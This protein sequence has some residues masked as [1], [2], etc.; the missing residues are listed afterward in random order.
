MDKPLRALFIEDVEDDAELLCLELKRGG[1]DV[2]YERVDTVDA[3]QAALNG[4]AWDF[5]LCD[6]TMPHLDAAKSLA[7]VKQ[8]G[9]DIPFIIVSGTIVEETAIAV[10]RGVITR[11][12]G[13]GA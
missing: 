1:L 3:L 13:S 6:F 7:A 5:V 2:S 9:L 10:M 8:K 12:C 4:E 11:S